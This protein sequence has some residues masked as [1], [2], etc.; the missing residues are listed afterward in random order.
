MTDWPQRVEA[1]L[2]E[3]LALLRDG[4]PETPDEPDPGELEPAAPAGFRAVYD[5]S[6]RRVTCSWTPQTDAVEVHER[7]KDPA[8]TLKATVAAGG[9]ARVSSELGGGPY[10]WALRSRR[11]DRVSA[12][13][14]WLR[15]DVAPAGGTDEP[16][17]P[18]G[19]DGEEPPPATGLLPA[20]VLDL[21]LWTLMLPR[22]KTGSDSPENDYAADWGI[23]PDLVFVR[24]DRGVVFRTPA[25]GDHSANS[26]YP[27]TELREM[28]DDDWIKASWS[29]AGPRTLTAELAIDA[30]GLST[31][32]RINGLQIHDGG[33]DVC[34]VM[35]HDELGLVLAHND[36]KSFESIDPLYVDGTRF[37]CTIAVANDR[38]AVDYNG[39]RRVDIPKKG[40][41]WYWKAGCYLQTGG[42]SEHREPAGATGEVVL[43]DLRMSP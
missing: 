2:D 10:E 1:K 21:R 25:D 33:D 11:G 32:K 35:R 12:F 17:A 3:V 22:L 20:D 37:T 23:V 27:R 16:E 38:I 8:A 34:Q 29:S 6:T 42:A 14:E 26:K 4:A 24:E 28:A 18:D 31:R 39:E 41:S 30:R 40:S 36:G 7:W 43:W 9:G 19:P 15:T 13:T 5:A